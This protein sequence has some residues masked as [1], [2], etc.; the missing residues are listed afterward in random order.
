MKKSED[1]PMMAYPAAA[2]HDVFS[3]PVFP[4]VQGLTGSQFSN[5]EDADGVFVETQYFIRAAQLCYMLHLAKAPQYKRSWC[6]RGLFGMFF[7]IARKWDRLEQLFKEGVNP[8][9]AP[10]EALEETIVD[11][12]VYAVKFLGWIA[13]HNPERYKALEE[14]VLAEFNKVNANEPTISLRFP[15]L[16]DEV[17]YDRQ[18]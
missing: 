1:G 5:L 17:V 13:E 11:L 15:L 2:K 9:T 10:G 18:P 6:R 3:A 16:K 4:I 12:A 8:W 7:T 14:R